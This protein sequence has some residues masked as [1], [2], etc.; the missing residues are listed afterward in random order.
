MRIEAL[1]REIGISELMMGAQQ[2]ATCSIIG[3]AQAAL[4]R[5]LPFQL[6]VL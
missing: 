5:D 4:I 3:K 1:A 2:P 6:G